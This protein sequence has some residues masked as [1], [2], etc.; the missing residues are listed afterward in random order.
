[1]DRAS[2]T[3]SES[4]CGF[5]DGGGRQTLAPCGELLGGPFSTMTQL[6][7]PVQLEHHNHRSIWVPRRLTDGALVEMTLR[8]SVARMGGTGAARLSVWDEVCGAHKGATTGKLR[9]TASREPTN[10]WDL[11][12]VQ[13]RRRLRNSVVA[14]HRP[15]RYLRGRPAD[16]IKGARASASRH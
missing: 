16:K 8:P 10:T 12:E 3:G 1:M 9:A 5:P 2:W 14:F 15:T 4:C 6:A 7:R 11:F 13:L